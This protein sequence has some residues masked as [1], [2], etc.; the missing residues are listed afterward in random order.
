MISP[1][2]R[3][4]AVDSVAIVCV[5]KFIGWYNNE[6][7]HSGIN[8]VT[9]VEHHNGKDTEILQKRK[10]LYEEAKSKYPES[11]VEKNESLGIW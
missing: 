4:E 2:D 10:V 7:R 3:R 11:L 1:S 6:H 5:E 9:L 8:Y